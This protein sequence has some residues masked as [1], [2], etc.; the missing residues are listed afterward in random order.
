MYERFFFSYR[1]IENK[2]IKPK[3]LTRNST[4]E[5]FFNF[6]L[7]CFINSIWQ[8]MVV[9]FIVTT[10]I[11]QNVSS[12]FSLRCREVS[13][14]VSVNYRKT[15]VGQKLCQ[16]TRTQ[17]AFVVVFTSTTVVAPNV[18]GNRDLMSNPAFIHTVC[19]TNFNTTSFHWTKLRI[20]FFAC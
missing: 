19:L 16:H 11:K 18:N 7:N 1:K 8:K 12:L 9:C 10:N 5:T 17:S 6:L 13:F 3:W 20:Y 2:K 4:I 14:K 15:Y